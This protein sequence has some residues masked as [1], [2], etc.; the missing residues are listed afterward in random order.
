VE[1]AR[2]GVTISAVAGVTIP[3]VAV[4]S[5]VVVAIPMPRHETAIGAAVTAQAADVI[6]VGRVVAVANVLERH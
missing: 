1:A 5:G 2:A 6:A 3:H 4:T